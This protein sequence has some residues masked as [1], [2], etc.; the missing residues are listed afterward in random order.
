MPDFSYTAKDKMGRPV[1]GVI[2]AENSA[3]AVG[4]VRELGFSPERV[5]AVDAPKRN[6]SLGRRFSE[7]FIF[8]VVNGVPLKDLATFYR[9]FST[10]I[11]AGIPLY[12]SLVAL[13]NQTRNPKL[14]EII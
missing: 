10:M 5:R 4:K 6:V 12:Q 7:N 1:E 13:E 11:G 8:P 2:F 9:Q 14:K 3:L